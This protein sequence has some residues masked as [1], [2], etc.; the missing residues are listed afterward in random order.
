MYTFVMRILTFLRLIRSYYATEW[1]QAWYTLYNRVYEYFIDK[2]GIR[3][4]WYI[5]THEQQT[6][7]VVL[8]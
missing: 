7:T 4:M 2:F 1:T 5:L 8:Y 6:K 3:M